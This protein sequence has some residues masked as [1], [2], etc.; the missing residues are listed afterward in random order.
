MLTVTGTPLSLWGYAGVRAGRRCRGAKSADTCG[1]VVP[2]T[3]L[4]KAIRGAPRASRANQVGASTGGGEGWRGSARRA[5][6]QPGGV[7]PV[8]GRRSAAGSGHAADQHAFQV[9]E[10]VFGGAVVKRTPR[11]P[12]EAVRNRRVR[13]RMTLGLSL[14]GAGGSPNSL[15]SSVCSMLGLSRGV[16]RAR[17]DQEPGSTRCAAQ[18]S[19]SS[20]HP[21]TP[22][23]AP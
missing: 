15:S 18:W 17:V 11:M 10:D 22:R 16:S 12:S 19:A 1:L 8:S 6:G 3:D 2:D 23:A 21:P 7:E 4:G 5:R 13:P 14:P 9:V 20:G